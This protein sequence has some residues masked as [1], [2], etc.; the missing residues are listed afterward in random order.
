MSGGDA[1]IKVIG[2][3]GGGGNAINRMVSSGLQVRSHSK[4][5]LPK[6]TLHTHTSSLSLAHRQ[7]F[8]ALGLQSIGLCL[9][10]LDGPYHAG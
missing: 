6:H 2:V 4:Q 8:H 9:L 1:R 7:G 10:T 5:D 3:G